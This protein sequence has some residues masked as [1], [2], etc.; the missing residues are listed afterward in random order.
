MKCT[1]TKASDM[2]YVS[3]IEINNL[4]ELLK[5]IDETEV[6]SV[7][8]NRKKPDSWDPKTRKFKYEPID[9]TEIIIYDDYLE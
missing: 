6:G 7:V 3:E 2:D 1:I 4:D 8:I 5:L 9:V